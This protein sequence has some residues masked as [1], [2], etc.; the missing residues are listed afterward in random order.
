MCRGVGD[1]VIIHEPACT[2]AGHALV[3]SSLVRRF[4]LKH[5]QRPDPSKRKR[6]VQ[7][8]SNENRGRKV[9]KTH[10]MEMEFFFF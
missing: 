1:E 3:Q 7:I 2:Q 9:K 6:H 5:K 8:A 10:K 4:N